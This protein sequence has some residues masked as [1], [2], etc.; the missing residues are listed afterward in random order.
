[1]LRG[2]VV[3][4]A[5]LRALVLAMVV[6]VAGSLPAAAQERISRIDVVGARS[7]EPESILSRIDL[8]PGGAYDAA[9]ADRA[10]LALYATASSRMSASS[11]A[12]VCSR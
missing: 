3:L 1:M 8:K 4:A 5:L 7:V 9:A 10:V 6:L 2:P 12:G 11:I